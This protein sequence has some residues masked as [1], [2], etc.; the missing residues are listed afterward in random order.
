MCQVTPF[1]YPC[2]N[3]I[4]VLVEKLPN[5]PADWPKSK[6][7]QE[8]C[9]QIIDTETA[10]VKQSSTGICWRCKSTAEGK[11]GPEREMMRPEIDRAVIVDGLEELDVVDRRQRAEAGGNCWYC[12]SRH[13]CSKYGTNKSDTA[14]EVPSPDLQRRKRGSEDPEGP[15][16]KR[17]VSSRMRSLFG[18][19][20]LPNSL[21]QLAF[22]RS[23]PTPQELQC[24]PT[25]NIA[26]EGFPAFHTD[27]HD[28][29]LV[30][31][32]GGIS[33][34]PTVP[35]YNAYTAFW[36]NLNSTH[37]YKTATV[38]EGRQIQDINPEPSNDLHPPSAD[39]DPGGCS[40]QDQASLTQSRCSCRFIMTV[41]SRP[42]AVTLNSTMLRYTIFW[43]DT[44]LVL[45]QAAKTMV[46]ILS[47]WRQ[48]QNIDKAT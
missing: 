46:E 34:W 1:T 14:T 26:H 10:Q 45:T 5:C 32:D 13:G 29:L 40:R 7:P 11:T 9:I 25:P 42:V 44:T 3:R 15:K 16:K 36:Q 20:S 31:S 37:G 6:C 38:G 30:M 33:S 28:C 47:K 35:S 41:S 22:R 2:C 27:N 48:L 24:L 17:K 12:G 8:L 21:P 4:Y 19:Q 43:M 39:I 18:S 23:G